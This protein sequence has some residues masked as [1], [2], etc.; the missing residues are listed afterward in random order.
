MVSVL[1]EVV[2]FFVVQVGAS[3]ILDVYSAEE[4]VVY[5]VRSADAVGVVGA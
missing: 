1:N 3:V 2:F 4:S 5:V